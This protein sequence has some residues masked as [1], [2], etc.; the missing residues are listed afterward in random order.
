MFHLIT[1]T[2]INE[3]FAYTFFSLSERYVKGG[4]VTAKIVRVDVGCTN[5]I[6]QYIDRILGIPDENIMSV[7]YNH[8]WL[9]KSVTHL[10]WCLALERIFI[11]CIP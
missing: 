9:K 6:V 7:I 5:G 4:Y 2:K 8:P 3:F 1:L 10:I 11:V